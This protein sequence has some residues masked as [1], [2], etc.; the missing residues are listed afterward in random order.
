MPPVATE[1]FWLSWMR[2]QDHQGPWE[3]SVSQVRLHIW[4]HRELSVCLSG[5]I[6][7]APTECSLCPLNPFPCPSR[8]A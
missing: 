4:G 2:W 5:V 8:N 6:T 1:E 7:L 3:G